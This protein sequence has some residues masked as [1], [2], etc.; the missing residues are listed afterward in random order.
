ML[1]P[2]SS[3]SHAMLRF[4]KSHAGETPARGLL[5]AAAMLYFAFAAV[6]IALRYWILP[7]IE[8]YRGDI[9]QAASFGLGRRVTIASVEAEWHGLNPY[10][11][12]HKVAIY[13]ESE[14]PAL[15][16]DLVES[17]LS[18]SSLWHL[19]LRQV[20]LEIWRPSL[21]VRRARN[22]QVYVAGIPLSKD[23]SGDN[24]AANWLLGQHE[25]A[26]RD[27]DMV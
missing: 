22:G 14:R 9:E 16:L 27:A 11:A 4:V 23:D 10:L 7:G 13:D 2:L 26:I 21:T 6:V 5:L 15:E 20:R 18:W 8:N 3:A 1:H 25:I 24:R 12:L 19:E 17:T